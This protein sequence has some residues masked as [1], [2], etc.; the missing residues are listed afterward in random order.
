MSKFTKTLVAA[1]ITG[2]VST[3]VT[4]GCINGVFQT[5]KK[6]AT[7]K[8]NGNKCDNFKVDVDMTLFLA[9]EGGSNSGV[10]ESSVFNFGDE[11]NSD[12]MYIASKPSRTLVMDQTADGYDDFQFFMDDYVFDNCS[13]GN[14]DG[15]NFDTVLK[16]FEAKVSKNGDK[17]NVKWDSEGTYLDDVK[18]K[19][20]KV[21]TKLSAKLDNVD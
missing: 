17:V 12:G 20:R 9:C 21:K 8:I 3:S 18:N 6:Q 16:K 19:D 2:F 14:E 7:L 15:Y 11:G 10:W 4:A 5:G 13:K 1:A